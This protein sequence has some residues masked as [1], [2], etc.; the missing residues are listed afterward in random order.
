MKTLAFVLAFLSLLQISGCSPEEK[1]A[2]PQL[3]QPHDAVPY[4]RFV[5]VPTPQ[6]GMTGLPWSGFF[7]L[8]TKTGILC[9]T[10]SISTG[11][12]ADY[13][14]SLPLCAALMREYPDTK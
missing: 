7:A 4:Q 11:R 12:L 2:P 10:S 8:D 14:E 13:K 9:L 1:A 5:P 3:Q 6:S